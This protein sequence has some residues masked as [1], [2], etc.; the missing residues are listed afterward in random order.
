MER[1]RCQPYPRA[2]Y[3]FDIRASLFSNVSSTG[4]LPRKSRFF[5]LGPCRWCHPGLVFE[6]AAEIPGVFVPDTGSDCFDT[7]VRVPEQELFRAGDP[8]VSKVLERR[9]AI[10]L[11]EDPVEVGGGVSEALGEC[12]QGDLLSEIDLKIL[13][14]LCAQSGAACVGGCG[15]PQFF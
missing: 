11:F 5:P 8:Q 4:R 2:E 6:D 7:D 10:L 13:G 14:D 15:L 3:V 12:G 9:D 1:S